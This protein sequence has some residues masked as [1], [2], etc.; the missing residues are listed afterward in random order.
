MYKCRLECAKSHEYSILV[1]CFLSVKHCMVF[2][3]VRN[4]GIYMKF[5]PF[6]EEMKYKFSCKIL[7]VTYCIMEF[8]NLKSVLFTFFSCIFLIRI[9]AVAKCK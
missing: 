2:I 3:A 8:L 6:T 1:I 4:I 9:S 5:Y 7:I